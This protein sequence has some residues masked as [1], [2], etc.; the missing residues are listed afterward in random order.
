MISLPIAHSTAVYPLAPSKI[1][2]LGLNYRK[3]IKESV[4]MNLS[5]TTDAIPGEPILFP[6]TPNTLITNGEKI[7]IPRF[8]KEQFDNPRTD[9]EG[10]LALIIGKKGKNIPEEQAFN[11]IY[12]YTCMNDVSQRNIQT[13]DKAGWFRGKSL[14]TFGPIGPCIVPTADIGNVQNLAITTRLNGKIV[15]ASNTS[16]MI[17][18]IPQII[19]FISTNF[20][21]LP[22]DIILTGTPE[23]VGP[24]K[25]GDNVEVEI[26]HIGTLTNTVIEE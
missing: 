12:G 24:L 26:E 7:I 16:H 8:V 10:E 22:G 15:Q 17:F 9:Y 6:K 14:D 18:T 3:H 25:H 23:G 4:S 11:H 21:L 20:T 5:G 19:H 13:G 2:A 1:I